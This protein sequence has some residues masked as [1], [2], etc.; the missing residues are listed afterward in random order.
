LTS[1]DAASAPLRGNTEMPVVN[2][3]AHRFAV[4]LELAGQRFGKLF[5][6][7]HA[8]GGLRAVDD[9]SELVA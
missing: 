5:G 8:G 7:C 1:N 4:D 6:E 9:Q 3:G 2:P